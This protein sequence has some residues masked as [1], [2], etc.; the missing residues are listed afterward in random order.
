MSDKRRIPQTIAKF[1]LF[2]RSF[3]AWLIQI[4][5]GQTENNAK[6]G[7]FHNRLSGAETSG[8]VKIYAWYIARYESTTGVMGDPS[9]PQKVEIF[10][11]VS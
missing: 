11:A 8:S 1:N 10:V 6:R 5:D 7:L 4:K 9:L 3:Y 2:V